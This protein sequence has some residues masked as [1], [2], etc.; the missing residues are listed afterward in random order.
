MGE[1]RRLPSLIE[2][3]TFVSDAIRIVNDRPLTLIS[4]MPNDLTLLTPSCFLGQQLSPNTPVSTF[5]DEGDLHR[6]FQYCAMLAQRFWLQW[7]KGYLPGLQGRNRWR[8]SRENL[9]VGQ[10][11]LVGDAEDSFRWGAYR[12]GR[13]HRLHPQLHVGKE[14]VRRATVAVLRKNTAA[15]KMEYILRDISNIAP[16]LAALDLF[17]FL[18]A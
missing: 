11:V 12:L 4:D 1:A 15:G 9:V 17:T 16:V 10:L 2:L 13:I 7:M 14:I 6:D 3:Q 5:P 8:T 18:V